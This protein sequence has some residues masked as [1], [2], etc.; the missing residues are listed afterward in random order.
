MK[1]KNLVNYNDLTVLPNPGI[2]FFFGEIMPKWP[3]Y[4]GLLGRG[5]AKGK[6]GGSL[7][8]PAWDGHD[9][10]F[11]LGIS[12][13]DFWYDKKWDILKTLIIWVCL[14]MVSILPEKWTCFHRENE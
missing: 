5:P 14:K 3:N 6:I 11:L 8:A 1:K 4:S 10:V 7:T 12:G 2:M 13:R 9:D